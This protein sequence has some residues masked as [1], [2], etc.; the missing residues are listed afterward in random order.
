MYSKA[1]E[2]HVNH[3]KQVFELLAK[4]QLKVKKSKCHFA[5]RQLS[6]LRH[7]ISVE[8]VATDPKKV[9]PIV[10]W[11]SPTDVKQLHSFLGMA[12]Y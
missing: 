2:D 3:V 5:Q 1:L 12:G 11:T 6:Y 10:K 7:V 9:A 8:G 4:H